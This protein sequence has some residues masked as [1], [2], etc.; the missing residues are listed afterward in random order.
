[1]AAPMVTGVSA[2][3][4]SMHPDYDNEQIRQLL[5]I[6][7][8]D[9]GDVG[10][11]TETRYGRVNATKVLDP[12][13]IPCKSL[14]LSPEPGNVIDG[15]V[16]IIGIS[17]G[18]KFSYYTLFYKELTEESWAQIGEN[19]YSPV[20][21]DSLEPWDVNS[22]ID[23]QYLLR[24]VTTDSNEIQYEDRSLVHIDRTYITYP[25]ESDIFR[26]G[27]AITIEGTV[28]WPDFNNYTIE[29]QN[30]E[31]PNAWHTEGIYLTDNGSNAIIDGCLAKFRTNEIVVPEAGYYNIR[32]IVNGEVGEITAIY[33]DPTL[34]EGWPKTLPGIYDNEY[35]VQAVASDLNHDGKNE[36]ILNS[37]SHL[38][39]SDPLLALLSDANYL[40]GWPINI[41]GMFYSSCPSVGDLEHDGFK[42]VV[43]TA[44]VKVDGIFGA[45]LYVFESNG[46]IK[47]GW[48]VKLYGDTFLYNS[49]LLSDINS[50]DHL[51][52]ITLSRSDSI[53]SKFV[54]TLEVF[55]HQGT[56]LPGQ[57]PYHISSSANQ[58]CFYNRLMVVGNMDDD[59]DLEIIY[60]N[61]LYEPNEI[62]RWKTELYVIDSNGAL[63]P[64]WPVV[65]DSYSKKSSPVIGDI[66]Q[67]G[68]NEIV[69]GTDNRFYALNNEGQVLWDIYGGTYSSDSPAIGDL[70]GDGYLEIVA[71]RPAWRDTIIWN[72]MG[73]TV[74][75]IPH[76]GLFDSYNPSQSGSTVIGD[77][78]GDG[79]PDI[80][81]SGNEK[82]VAWDINGNLIKGF[83]KQIG[84]GALM[85][86]L[87]TD[88]DNDG[89]TDLVAISNDWE[90]KLRVT[91][92]VWNLNSTY[93]KDNLEWPQFHN[94]AQRTGYYND[95]LVNGDF[96]EDFDVDT[97]DL[98]GFSNRW[99]A[100]P[101]QI[102]WHPSFD[103]S[104]PADNIIDLLD[105]SIFSKHW[106]KGTTP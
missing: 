100:E 59:P 8:D 27:D 73:E 56:P 39:Y 89:L 93:N 36:I 44:S 66:N 20:S 26:F 3:I 99:L 4:A 15:L 38:I 35:F 82:V 83:P 19:H 2:L 34:K 11:D 69:I 42:E 74:K 31:D 95:K 71:N 96:D 101:N 105:F 86:P 21:I 65:L 70:T 57:W 67:D 16:D 103:I 51:E 76:A 43:C 17:G 14:I 55:D 46:E 64:N 6:Q 5:R 88:L 81:I 41:D 72:Y 12:N 45:Y 47:N 85:T 10:W 9:V 63:L 94:N 32:I 97:D 49:V 84:K 25:Q 48:P 40:E 33:L 106:F 1:M 23:G 53:V 78:N 18:E 79:T 77:I 7:S 50:D 62:S 98:Y 13:I 60:P 58:T 92:Y 75:K 87:I 24:L 52:I 90:D 61:T 102:N 37:P 80:V 104:T 22:I 30:S 54:Y 28:A 68:F 29:Y 91:I